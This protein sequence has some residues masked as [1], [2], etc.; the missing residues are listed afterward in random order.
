[1]KFLTE[2][3]IAETVTRD[4][5]DL[6]DRKL[7]ID[8]LSAGTAAGWEDGIILIFLLTGTADLAQVSIT[9]G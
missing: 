5:P 9:A 1:L 4:I 3:C 6:E 8:R 7:L 2:R